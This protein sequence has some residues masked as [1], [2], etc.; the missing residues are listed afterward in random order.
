MRYYKLKDAE[1][2]IIEQFNKNNVNVA[3]I[4]CDYNGYSNMIDYDMLMNDIYK[5]LRLELEPIREA[6]IYVLNLN[7]EEVQFYG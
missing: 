1:R 3:M 5:D 4:I 6:D 2:V 7:T